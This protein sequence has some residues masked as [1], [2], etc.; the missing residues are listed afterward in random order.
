MMQEMQ[1]IFEHFQRF[2]F[3]WASLVRPG[4]SDSAHRTIMWCRPCTNGLQARQDDSARQLVAA[5]WAVLHCDGAAAVATSQSALG[6]GSQQVGND[7]AIAANLHYV[8][9]RM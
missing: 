9:F 6:I 8:L 5:G 1:E 3:R 7:V 2:A 4:E